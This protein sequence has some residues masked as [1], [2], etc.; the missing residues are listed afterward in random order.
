MPWDDEAGRFEHPRSTLMKRLAVGGV[1]IFRRPRAV[2]PEV[3]ECH[4]ALLGADK[5]RDVLRGMSRRFPQHDRRRHQETFGRPA[6]PVF[7]VVHRPMIVDPG[8]GEHADVDGVIG[9]VMADD[10]ISDLGGFET[11]FE[12]RTGDGRLRRGHARIDND[13]LIVIDDQADGG[14]N[15]RASRTDLEDVPVGVQVWEPLG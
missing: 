13:Q 6:V 7:V 12:Q 1:G 11:E 3:G 5:C 9:M 4:Q 10:D 14:S 2:E 8:V 15:P